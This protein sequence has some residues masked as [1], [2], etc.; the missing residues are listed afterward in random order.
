[1][2]LI[3]IIKPLS[4]VL[5]SAVNKSQQHQKKNSLERQGLNLGLQGAKQESSPKCYVAQ[6][7]KRFVWIRGRR[8]F[9]QRFVENMPQTKSSSLSNVLRG[10]SVVTKSRI[11]ACFSAT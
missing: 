11:G 3:D 9:N 8:S 5:S 1:M 10:L 2:G 6:W 4:T 7:T